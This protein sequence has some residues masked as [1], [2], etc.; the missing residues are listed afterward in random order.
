MYWN[1]IVLNLFINLLFLWIHIVYV[2]IARKWLLK[3]AHFTYMIC[4]RI[5]FLSMKLL[6]LVK[7][8]S[9]HSVKSSSVTSINCWWSI[10]YSVLFIIFEG[11]V[12]CSPHLFAFKLIS[13]RGKRHN[14]KYRNYS[15]RL[16]SH[17]VLGSSQLRAEMLEFLINFLQSVNEWCS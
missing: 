3:C 13:K 12:V 16:I 1:D 9:Q 7:I 15:L 11:S 2:W 8:F 4:L 6:A 14:K 17:R 10:F 5:N